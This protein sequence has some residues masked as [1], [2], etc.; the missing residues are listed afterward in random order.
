MLAW[1]ESNNFQDRLMES[2]FCCCTWDR[3][4][5]KLAIICRRHYLVSLLWTTNCLFPT[6]VQGIWTECPLFLSLFS[7]LLSPSCPL[8]LM[9]P[10]AMLWAVLWRGPR[11]K[12]S[13][14]L[15]P[16]VR[17]ELRSSETKHCQQCELG[18]RFFSSCALRWLWPCLVLW[19]QHW[20]RPWARTSS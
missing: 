17:V 11:G 14:G 2:F 6:G 13:R 4:I 7:L 10:T 1:W 3:F 9:K 16:A 15:Q 20:E 19:L 18:C 12:E 8:S 5:C